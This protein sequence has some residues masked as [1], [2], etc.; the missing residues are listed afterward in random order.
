MIDEYAGKSVVEKSSRTGQ[1]RI[2]RRKLQAKT[3]P[4]S[5]VGEVTL[6][7]VRVSLALIYFR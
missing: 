1:P 4:R 7:V 3:G 6:Y 2:G 5:D